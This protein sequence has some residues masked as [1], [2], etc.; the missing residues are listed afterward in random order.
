MTGAGTGIGA[1]VAEAFA[2]EGASLVLVGRRP[3]PLEATRGL[4]EA[5]A[6]RAGSRML[7]HPCD[8]R[9]EAALASA[10]DRASEAGPIEAVVTAHG[11]NRLATIASTTRSAWE[12][13]VATNLTGTFLVMREALR[14]M[15]SHGS[16]R[17]VLVSSV[18]GRPGYTKFAGFAPYSASKYGLTGLLEVA[19]VEAEGSGVEVAMIAPGGVETAM[20]RDTFPGAGA[21]MAP[22]RVAAAILDLADRSVPLPDEGVLELI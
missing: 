8:V 13:I 10:F 21:G 17:I 1:A 6:P 12:E 9:D 2:A 4:C 16:G 11:V 15:T 20:F 18:S 7:A 5:V 22:R 19:R 3:A 14:R